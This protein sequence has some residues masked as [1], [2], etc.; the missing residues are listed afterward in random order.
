MGCARVGSDRQGVGVSGCPGG[1][2]VGGHGGSPCVCYREAVARDSVCEIVL[3]AHA[4]TT[5][6]NA[7][8]IA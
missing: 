7:F 4:F 1:P 3:A 8:I 2:G 5:L 6:C